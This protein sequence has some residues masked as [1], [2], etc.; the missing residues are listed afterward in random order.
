M[1]K[2]LSEPSCRIPRFAYRTARAARDTH[3]DQEEVE[4]GKMGIVGTEI[5]TPGYAQV[6]SNE[7]FV[8]KGNQWWPPRDLLSETKGDEFGIGCVFKLDIPA[9]CWLLWE[10]TTDGVRIM[11]VVRADDVSIL[12]KPPNPNLWP[13][14]P[15]VSVITFVEQPPEPKPP[16]EPESPQPPPSE[17]VPSYI[18]FYA[19][20]TANHPKVVKW[21][22]WELVVVTPMDMFMEFYED[23]KRFVE[24]VSQNV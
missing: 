23:F 22:D 12:D 7:R 9:P 4:T 11:E 13:V 17:K 10:G 5:S 2:S 20:P 16:F 18:T 3:P 24:K 8:L 19:D 15:G 1:L 6:W 14:Y 21:G